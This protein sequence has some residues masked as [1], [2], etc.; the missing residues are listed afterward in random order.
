MTKPQRS[1]DEIANS[2]EMK[3]LNEREK[4]YQF[5]L[6]EFK[7]NGFTEKQAKYLIVLLD[8]FIPLI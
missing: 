5:L 4:S 1:R 3:E 8:S 2:P 6:K 7:E